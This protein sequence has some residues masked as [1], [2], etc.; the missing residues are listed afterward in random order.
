MYLPH[1]VSAFTP[2]ASQIE[3]LRAKVPAL[4]LKV[5]E[6]QAE[7]LQHLP[8]SQVVVVWEFD[9]AWYP[10]APRLTWVATPAAG[11]EGIAPDPAGLCRV[12]HGTFHGPIMAESALS[13]IGFMNR[14]FGDALVAQQQHQWRREVYTPTRPLRGQTALIVGYGAIGKHVGLLLASVGVRIWALKRDVT[15]GGQ[16]AARVYSPSELHAALAGADHVVCILPGDTDSAGL[17]GPVAFEHMKSTAFIYN[18]G[19]GAAI[20]A[21]ALVAALHEGQIAGGFLD[22]FEDEP[23]AADSELWEAPHLYLTPHASAIRSDYLDLYF[24]ELATLLST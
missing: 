2:T 21:P 8:D 9:Q 19:R 24:D 3:R 14:R 17:I 13:M 1:G 23:L 4:D 20:D 15:R 16:G 5:V 6:G 7:F 11:R 10:L 22:V 18:L 12:T